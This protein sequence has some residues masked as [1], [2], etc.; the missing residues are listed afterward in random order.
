MLVKLVP[1]VCRMND[2]R[3]TE[4]IGYWKVL[5]RLIDAFHRWL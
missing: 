4:R 3:N 1:P 2:S 5:L